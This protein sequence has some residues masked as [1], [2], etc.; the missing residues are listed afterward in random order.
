[1]ET[2]DVASGERFSPELAL[3]SL[4]VPVGHL[5][6]TG[7]NST[8]ETRNRTGFLSAEVAEKYSACSLYV[9]CELCIMCAAALSI[10]GIKEVYYDCTNDKCVGCGSILL[11][12]QVAL[13]NELDQGFGTMAS[14]AISLLQDFYEQENPNAGHWLHKNPFRS[15]IH[16]G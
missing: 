16:Q 11:L 7:R 12:H 2:S 4:E 9:I 14:K 13:R 5:T 10:I 6:V 3:D 8:N 15:L 1:M